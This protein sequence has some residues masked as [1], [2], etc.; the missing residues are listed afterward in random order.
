MSE[1][2]SEDAVGGRQNEV[3]C[4]EDIFPLDVLEEVPEFQHTPPP[5]EAGPPPYRA[6]P[7]PYEAGPPPYRAMLPPR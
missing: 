7:P 1:R 3:I 2:R 4:P 5:Y 6:V